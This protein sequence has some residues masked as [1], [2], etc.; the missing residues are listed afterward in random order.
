[1]ALIITNHSLD[2]LASSHLRT[3]LPS[4]RWKPACPQRK[5]AGPAGRSFRPPSG[6]AAIAFTAHYLRI[7]RVN[8]GVQDRPIILIPQ[9]S[10]NTISGGP[11]AVR[12][13]FPGL[14]RVE[15][16]GPTDATGLSSFSRTTLR[17]SVRRLLAGQTSLL[18]LCRL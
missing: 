12:S 6:L 17:N 5:V 3:R 1:M 14:V 8:L 10:S 16:P 4:S 18:L 2:R 15:S 13:S 9:T 11:L 7:M